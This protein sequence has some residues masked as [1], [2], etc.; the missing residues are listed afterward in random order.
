MTETD[1]DLPSFLAGLPAKP[2]VYRMLDAEGK[3]L[4]V[5]KPASSEPGSE[6]LPRPRAHQQDAGHA[7]AD[8]ADRGDR[9]GLGD[10]GAAA[11][12]EPDQAAPAALQRAAPRRQE[13]SYIQLATAH[14]YL[15]FVLP[16]ATPRTKQ[17]LRAV[18]SSIPTRETRLLLQKLFRVRHAKTRSSRTGRARA[19][20]TR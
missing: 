1:F 4:Y 6:L 3:V 18:P 13:L 16:R 11:R 17:V 20:N 10:R 14:E 5:V 12:G 19:C 9:N 8:V 15:G 7:R 2:G